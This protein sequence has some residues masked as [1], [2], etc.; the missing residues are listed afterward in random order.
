MG[1]D[2]TGLGSVADLVT[3]VVNKFWPDKTQAEKDAA[4]FQL[5]SLVIQSDLVKGQLAI[6]QAEAASSD[7]LQHWRGGMGWTCV[8]AYFWN[9]IGQP[10]TC[11]ISLAVGHPINPVPLDIGPLATITAGMLGLGSLHVAER[12]KGAS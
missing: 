2:V 5:Q 1:L 9:F 10:L 11:T 8:F 12:I 7:P 6:N 4:A 3:S